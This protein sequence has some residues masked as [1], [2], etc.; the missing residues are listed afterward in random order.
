MKEVTIEYAVGDN[1]PKARLL[2]GVHVLEGLKQLE[3]DSVHTICTSPPYWGLRDYG[4]ASWKGGDPDCNHTTSKDPDNMKAHVDRPSGGHRGGSNKVCIH[5]GAVR[6]DNQ[7]G[8]ED[9]IHEYVANIVAVFDECKRVLRK[10][11]TLWL[12]LGDSYAGGGGSSGHNANTTNMG[13]PTNSYGSVATGGR[14]PNGLK[15]K[16]LVGIPWR[17]ALALQDA[18]WYLRSDI[19]WAKGSCMPE[20]VRDRPTKAHEYVFLFAHPD[21]GGKYFYDIEAVKEPS[22]TGDTVV[23]GSGGVLG[24]LNKGRREDITETHSGTTRNKRSVWKVN[25]S[26]F[27]GAHFACWPPALVEPMVKAGTSSR[28]CCSVCGSPMKRITLR[29]PGGSKPCPKTQ[30]SHEARGGGGTATGTVGKSGGSRIDPSVQTLGWEPTCDCFAESER[31][32]VLDPFSGSATTGQVA[33]ELGRDYIG[34][35]LNEDYLALA[36]SRLLGR[37]HSG[38]VFESGGLLEMLT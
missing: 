20:S 18:G 2:Y 11:G 31:C 7:I 13:R 24:S 25:P 33:L 17:V 29:T 19:I 10:D 32:V 21:S 1:P 34:I 14:T 8:L 37:K 9:D 12:N 26:G 36:E 27:K 5:C 22:A 38:K 23:R 4:T 6:V 28:G 3:D 15:P 16:D 35:D 30:A